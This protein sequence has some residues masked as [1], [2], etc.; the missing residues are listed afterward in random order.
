MGYHVKSALSMTQLEKL[1]GK[2]GDIRLIVCKLAPPDGSSIEAVDRTRRLPA[3][4][5][6]SV[7]I[8]HDDSSPQK[9]IDRVQWQLNEN[10]WKSKDSAGVYLMDLPGSGAAYYPVLT[11]QVSSRRVPAMNDVQRKVFQRLGTDALQGAQSTP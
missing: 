1:V 6:A 3:G 4:R 2:G 7:V 11:D 5:L 9:S 8:F 10:R